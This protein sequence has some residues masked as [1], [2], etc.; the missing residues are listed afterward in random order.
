MLITD[1]EHQTPAWHV[2]YTTY[3]GVEEKYPLALTFSKTSTWLAMEDHPFSNLL[4]E[5]KWE[6]LKKQPRGDNPRGD[7][8]R[9]DNPLEE[10]YVA[11]PF[12]IDHSCHLLAGLL[13]VVG[14]LLLALAERARRTVDA[15]RRVLSATTTLPSILQRGH[16][17]IAFTH[18]CW[19]RLL[20]QR[21]VTPGHGGY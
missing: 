18:L 17:Q 14:V 3:P 19:K 20:I 16:V 15:G 21:L 7:N 13:Q 10:R 1:L 8:S 11:A 2:L 4:T 12:K 9:D 6:A 5:V